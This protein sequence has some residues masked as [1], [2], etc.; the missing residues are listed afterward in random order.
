MREL[1]DFTLLSRLRDDQ[2]EKVRKRGRVIELD[3]HAVLHT[4][5]DICR[6]VSFVLAGRLAIS[7]ILPSGKEYV[8]RTLSEG[9]SFGEMV[10]FS[11]D[12]VYPGWIIAASSCRVLEI[13]NTLLLECMGDREFLQAFL[14]E[15]SRH[16]LHLLQRM[17]FLNLKTIRQKIAGYLLSRLDTVYEVSPDDRVATYPLSK[18]L[19]EPLVT[20]VQ[21]TQ[22]AKLLGNSREAVSRELARLEKERVLERQGRNI[23][24][25]NLQ[26]LEDILMDEDG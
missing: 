16:T 7:R 2:K 6:N 1:K 25:L 4:P 26:L 3:T 8:I 13:E 10:A 11:R 15:L 20:A 21:K 19:K 5:H 14:E 24:I 22:L 18:T 9:D 23:K 12:A 17:E